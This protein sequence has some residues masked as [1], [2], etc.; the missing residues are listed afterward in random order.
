MNFAP[1]R[2][3]RS[4]IY[5]GCATLLAACSTSL[6]ASKIDYKTD[7]EVKSVGQ[8]VPPDLTQLTRDTRYALP[9]RSE[10]HH[11]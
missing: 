8:E 3:L 11:V 2:F 5:I 1:H 10:E 4:T 6:I 7:V 9:G